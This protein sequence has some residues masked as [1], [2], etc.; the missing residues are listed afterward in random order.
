MHDDA[1][2]LSLEL[3]EKFRTGGLGEE[4]SASEK[5]AADALQAAHEY[6]TFHGHPHLDAWRGEQGERRVAFIAAFGE[7]AAEANVKPHDI[8]SASRLLM[9]AMDRGVPIGDL[10]SE[11]KSVEPDA[12]RGTVVSRLAIHI[13][14]EHHRERFLAVEAS[15]D[16]R[17]VIDAA[18]QASPAAY[19]KLTNRIDAAEGKDFQRG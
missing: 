17:P 15:Q 14:G 7:Q 3:A 18:A 4:R 6:Y 1:T 9:E 11:V 2:R 13:P 19:M 16:L 5:A 10:S 8:R 12:E